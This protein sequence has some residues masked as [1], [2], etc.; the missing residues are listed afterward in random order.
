[1]PHTLRA[2]ASHTQ[3]FPPHRW[4]AGG[5]LRA[6]QERE[7]ALTNL[8]LFIMAR[9]K[10]VCQTQLGSR[11]RK[12]PPESTLCRP[13]TSGQANTL[14]SLTGTVRTEPQGR[15]GSSQQ[16]GSVCG[17]SAGYRLPLSLLLLGHSCLSRASG[18]DGLTEKGRG[19]T[20]DTKPNSKLYSLISFFDQKIS[21]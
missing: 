18:C 10:G 20:Q 7:R 6:A 11:G 14:P 15:R 21:K 12:H 4:K 3:A 9:Q 1:M 16:R 5:S 2:S 13:G 17:G 8:H 19:R